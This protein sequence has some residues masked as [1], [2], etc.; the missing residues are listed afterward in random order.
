MTAH[1]SRPSVEHER[2]DGVPVKLEL[3][4]MKKDGCT[5]D[6]YLVAPR[7]AFDER[8]VDFERFVRGPVSVSRR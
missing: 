8:R 6:L 2:L 4:V 3:V 1:A 7:P 5:V